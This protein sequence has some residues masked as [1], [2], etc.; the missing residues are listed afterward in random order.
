VENRRQLEADFDL[1]ATP[2]LDDAGVATVRRR[3]PMQPDQLLNPAQW[4]IQ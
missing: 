1:F 4:S 3:L 2:P